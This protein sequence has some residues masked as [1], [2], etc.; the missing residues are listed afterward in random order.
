VG[1]HPDTPLN[2]NLNI[3]NEN[4]D[5]KI[6]TVCVG[7]YEDGEVNE[8]DEGEG[9]WLMDFIHLYVIEQRNL[10]QLLLVEWGEG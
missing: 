2:S 5:N 7:V 8:G 10:L 9:I 1:I 6:G 3:T 4:Q